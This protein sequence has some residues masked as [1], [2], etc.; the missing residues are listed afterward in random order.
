MRG[1]FRAVADALIRA[2][3]EVRPLEEDDL[4]RKTQIVFESDL[5]LNVHVGSVI[6][7]TY[8]VNTDHSMCMA[9]VMCYKIFCRYSVKL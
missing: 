2:A 9:E 6:I 7:M 8:L 4:E 3:L 1:D 5:E